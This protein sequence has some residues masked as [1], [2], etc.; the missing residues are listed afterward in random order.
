M[1]FSINWNSILQ[2]LK[3]RPLMGSHT[4]DGSLWWDLILVIYFRALVLSFMW[5]IKKNMLVS[6]PGN[7]VCMFLPCTVPTM[8]KTRFVMIWKKY[9]LPFHFEK[10][11]K[12]LKNGTS[13]YRF[14]TWKLTNIK[15][16]NIL[17]ML[18]IHILHLK[19]EWK[20]VLISARYVWIR[21]I[22]LC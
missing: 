11:W 2:M 4:V 17:F 12:K 3:L 8:V 16:N 20:I 6:L 15:Y 19:L 9:F 10:K 7:R 22:W 14:G 5:F 1:L 13:K 21:Q 18:L